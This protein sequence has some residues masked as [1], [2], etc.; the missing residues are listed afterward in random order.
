MHVHYLIHIQ[1]ELPGAIAN[2]ANKNKFE[3]T[4]T[5][6]YKNDPFPTINS[7]DLL[8]IMGGPMNIYEYEK[9]P[10]LADEKEFI[11]Q[12]IQA[13]KKILGICLGAQL[14]ADVLGAKI[15][16]NNENEIGWFPVQK[17]TLAEKH[18]ITRDLQFNT[19]LHWHGDRF[20]IPENT[21]HLLKSEACNQQAFIYKNTVL[22]FQFHIEMIPE[23][24]D[25]MIELDRDTLI[26]GRWVMPEQELLNGVKNIS[27]NN[28]LLYTILNRFTIQHHNTA[29]NQK[30]LDK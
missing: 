14:I 27:A 4:Y 26:K 12:T 20:D 21:T 23:N 30:E 25:K 1:E 5:Y 22:A 13:N 15:V 7:F 18:P 16:S 29:V 24:L 19:V 28:N 2:W 17:T 3:Q 6:L 11:Q 9:Y 10:W 8:V